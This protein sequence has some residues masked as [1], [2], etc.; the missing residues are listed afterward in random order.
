VSKEY[1]KNSNG[2]RFDG[3]IKSA[4]EAKQKQLERF[5]AAAGDPEKLA[6]RAERQAAA[7]AREELRKAQAAK[8]MLEKEELARRKAEVAAREAEVEAERSEVANRKVTK[9]VA[10]EEERKAERDRRYAARR[11][12]KR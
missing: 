6:K 7:A 9:K 12:R 10:T 1:M 3:R 8:L 4:S 2:D 5:K 11:D